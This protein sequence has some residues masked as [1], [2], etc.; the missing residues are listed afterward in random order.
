MDTESGKRRTV[1][2]APRF[3][4]ASRPLHL[5]WRVGV[6]V[7]GLAVVVT[8]VIL[9]PLPG[10]GW[11]VIFGG[12]AIWATEFSWAQAVMRYTRRK[13]R[14][15]AEWAKRRRAERSGRSER[16]TGQQSTP[17]SDE[18]G[19]SPEPDQPPKS[20]PAGGQGPSDRSSSTSA[21]MR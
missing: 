8:G 2:R 15:G 3:I 14:Q 18:A 21:D 20:S 19:T 16:E 13:L 7:V 5:S 11:V 1:S 6:F 12:M 10:P 17:P 4:K 9:L